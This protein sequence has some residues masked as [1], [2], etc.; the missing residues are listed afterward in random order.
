M[1]KLFFLILIFIFN[2][3]SNGQSKFPIP[4]K[5]FVDHKLISNSDS[6]LTIQFLD[7]DED[8]ILFVKYN[9]IYFKN[10]IFKE[11]LEKMDSIIIKINTKSELHFATVSKIVSKYCFIEDGI[12]RSFYTTVF[13]RGPATNRIS[14]NSHVIVFCIKNEKPNENN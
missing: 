4:L 9:N 11:E 7:R 6:L 5:V 2:L 8:R 12:D 14:Q 3:S 13:V 1:K 10:K